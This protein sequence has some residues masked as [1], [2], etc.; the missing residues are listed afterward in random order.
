MTV[1]VAPCRVSPHRQDRGIRRPSAD[2]TGGPTDG[3]CRGPLHIAHACWRQARRHACSGVTRGSRESSHERLR[4]DPAGVARAGRRAHQ[5]QS[6]GRHRR[7]HRR[8]A[9]RLHARQLRAGRVGHL[10]AGR[11]AP[12]GEGHAADFD[13]QAAQPQRGCCWR[14]ITD[15]IDSSDGPRGIPRLSRSRAAWRHR[16][17][18][19]A[20]S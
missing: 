10:H 8:R 17:G 14:P 4:G 7:G 9:L 13:N 5:Q 20:S 19:V 3:S 11:R 1:S 12:S 6:G 15:W 16:P 18:R 2:P